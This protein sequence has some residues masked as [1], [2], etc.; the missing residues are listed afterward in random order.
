MRVTDTITAPYTDIAT[1][2]DSFDDLILTLQVLKARNS[3]IN[4]TIPLHV[5]RTGSH[6]KERSAVQIPII[7]DK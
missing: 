2:R 4:K 6:A 1:K 3:P 7:L 5:K